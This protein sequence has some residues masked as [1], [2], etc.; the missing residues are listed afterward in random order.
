MTT[1]RKP[2]TAPTIEIVMAAMK[3][4]ASELY[5]A[6]EKDCTANRTHK[7]TAQHLLEAADALP[8]ILEQMVSAR[9]ARVF[10]DQE[11]AE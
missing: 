9:I 10:D 2:P 6:D 3:F 5:C 4:A 7:T 8:A 11:A 1:P